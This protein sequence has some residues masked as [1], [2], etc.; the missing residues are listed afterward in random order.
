MN[1]ADSLGGLFSLLLL[2]LLLGIACLRFIL[3]TFYTAMLV[4]VAIS[5]VFS[6]YGLFGLEL[7]QFFFFRS[8]TLLVWLSVSFSQL[9]FHIIHSHTERIFRIQWVFSRFKSIYLIY[10][11]FLSVSFRATQSLSL[12]VFFSI[13]KCS[14]ACVRFALIPDQEDRR[15]RRRR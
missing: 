3:Y 9:L 10:G 12:S 15:R 11:I 14:N 2:L 4:V 5:S 8:F 7:E 1:L 13:S 6:F